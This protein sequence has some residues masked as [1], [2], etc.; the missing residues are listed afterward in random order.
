MDQWSD[1]GG[2]FSMNLIL[3]QKTILQFLRRPVKCH[4][5]LTHFSSFLVRSYFIAKT[6]EKIL[7][8]QTE[9]Y[10]M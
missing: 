6:L 9:Q 5:V 8:G 4:N 2:T 1:L 7:E 3:L 10:E